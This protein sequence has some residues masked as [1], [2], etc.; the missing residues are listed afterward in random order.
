EAIQSE[1]LLHP[2]TRPGKQI[3]GDKFS[4]PPRPVPPCAGPR[5]SAPVR[6]ALHV[7]VSGFRREIPKPGIVYFPSV[8]PLSS[9]PRRRC[10]AATRLSPLR[11]IC[12]SMDHFIRIRI[13]KKKLVPA[14]RDSCKPCP[15]GEPPPAH[16]PCR[17]AGMRPPRG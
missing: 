11:P 2:H 6:A 14:S 17:A 1:T 15:R 4:A 7:P 16:T 8:P 13:G 9:P 12:Q 5:L 10:R 3:A